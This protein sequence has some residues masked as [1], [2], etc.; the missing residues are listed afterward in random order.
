MHE[1]HSS[2]MKEK[3]YTYSILH[4]THIRQDLF[5]NLRK[6]FLQF[7]FFDYEDQTTILRINTNINILGNQ[8]NLVQYAYHYLNLSVNENNSLLDVVI[9]VY[10]ATNKTQ[11][12]CS[13][14]YF[15]TR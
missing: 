10:K 15:V 2:K 4:Y 12:P 3:V 13:R 11:F 8:T 14:F 1:F 5:D 7:T 6:Y 9:H